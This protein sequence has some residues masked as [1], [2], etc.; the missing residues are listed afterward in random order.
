MHI[1]ISWERGPDWGVRTNKKENEKRRRQFMW[2]Q[3]TK[4]EKGKRKKEVKQRGEITQCHTV[5]K[6]EKAREKNEVYFCSIEKHKHTGAW[7]VRCSPRQPIAQEVKLLT[8]RT[9]PSHAKEL[10]IMS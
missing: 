5:S 8:M 1:E 2:T 9:P 7:R 10:M 3:R 6:G 4:C